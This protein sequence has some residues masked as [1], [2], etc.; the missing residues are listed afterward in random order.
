LENISQLTSNAWGANK[1]ICMQAMGGTTQIKNFLLD[2]G[3][4]IPAK[5]VNT[6][7]G[8][9]TVPSEKDQKQTQDTLQSTTT[10]T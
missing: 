5:T 6:T 7:Q 4:Y 10:Q 3:K 9:T 2:N 1:L 8:F